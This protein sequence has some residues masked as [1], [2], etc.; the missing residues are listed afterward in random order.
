MRSSNIVAACCFF[1]FA[2]FAF[3]H[4]ANAQ[5]T[6]GGTKGAP[7]TP[8]KPKPAKY[9]S[10]K[11]STKING[12]SAASDKAVLDGMRWLVRHQNQDGSWSVRG[13]ST[14]CRTSPPCNPRDT[15][16]TAVGDV[17]A[18]SLAL[19]SFLAMGFS[20]ASTQELVDTAMGERHRIGTRVEKG[21]VWL[22]EQQGED[23]TWPHST[24]NLEAQALGT[25]A[26]G[27]AFGMTSDE[28]MKGPA[29]KGLDA[30][31]RMQTQSAT[32]KARA[33]WKHEGSDGADDIDATLW[34]V[35][36]LYAARVV[37]LT[38]DPQ[39]LDGAWRFSERALK[40]AAA[41]KPGDARIAKLALI[42]IL[43]RP[44][45]KDASMQRA[46]DSILSLLGPAAQE[47]SNALTDYVDAL[48][49]SQLH[50]A[51]S[52][53]RAPEVWKRWI[54]EWPPTLMAS[55]DSTTLNCHAG[56]WLAPDPSCPATSPVVTTALRM[57][58]L[59]SFYRYESVF[60][61]KK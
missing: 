33:G 40:E 9:A 2:A 60:A 1:A 49:M 31:V 5:D 19:A 56:G 22:I 23:G 41:A 27:D 25:L 4:R 21:L 7:S 8:E 55:Q 57:L 37:H 54:A 42:R 59:E 51:D 3:L 10:R 35:Q 43:T 50:G 47:K 26:L 46:T 32:D 15:S 30:L 17:G 12:A 13:L 18:T 11:T 45:R 58:A 39:A 20:Q 6:G 53:G 52:V 24:C 36:A 61:A 34:A 48:V 14:S 44:D 38:V 29:Q 28:R 16:A